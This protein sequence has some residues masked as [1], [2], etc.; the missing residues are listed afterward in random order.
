MFVGTTQANRNPE[1]YRQLAVSTTAVELADATGGIPSSAI[2]AEI[3]VSG[4]SVRWRDDGVAPTATV[5]MVAD[6]GD[7]TRF[8]VLSSRKQINN[9]Q[10]IREVGDAELNIS[11]YSAHPAY[12]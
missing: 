3:V 7:D 11:Y 2:Y 5:G 12:N 9:F 1:G 4:D 6:E 8:I 10:A